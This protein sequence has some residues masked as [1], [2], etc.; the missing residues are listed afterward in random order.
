VPLSRRCQPGPTRQ[1]HSR[2]LPRNRPLSGKWASLVSTFLAPVTKLSTGSPPATIRPVAS[3][4]SRSPARFGALCL[5]EPSRRPI[6]S[7][8]PVATTVRHH[9]RRKHTSLM[10]ATSP[11][12]TAWVPIKR[13]ARAPSF[14]TLASATPSP[15][16]LDLIELHAAAPP[17][18]PVSSALFSL[19]SYNQIN[20][21]LELHHSLTNTTHPFPSPIAPG[22]LAGDPT[23]ADARHLAV[24]RPPRA[25]T[26]QI[27]PASVTPTISRAL[28]PLRR[29]RTG[30][31][32]KNRRGTSPA[33]VLTAANRP[34]SPRPM[35]LPPPPSDVWARTHGVR[36]CRS[37]LP[38]AGWAACPR[39]PAL[40]WAEIPPAQLAEK[41]LFFFL[42]P[43]LFPIFTYL[44]IY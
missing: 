25:S 21:A 9:R 39:A 28:P 26:G 36:P 34:F 22:N 24:D 27:G 23:A 38:W 11:P 4:L 30:P 17:S 42:F 7:S 41:T 33:A 31:P 16:P 44:C 3:P 8:H 43:F 35:P 13:T 18:A 1:P 40:G 32:T 12:F 19:L 15:P 6:C 37:S 20:V 2:S 14:L 29:R 10:R 5:P